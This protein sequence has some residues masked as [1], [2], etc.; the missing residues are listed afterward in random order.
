MRFGTGKRSI[1]K[2]GKATVNPA[3]IIFSHI[4]SG[5]MGVPLLVIHTLK[6]RLHNL[7]I[8]L[9]V[10]IRSEP[11]FVSNQDLVSGS[12]NEHPQAVHVSKFGKQI[13]GRWNVG[14]IE[15]G[16][17]IVSSSKQLLHFVAH[18]LGETIRNMNILA[19]LIYYCGVCGRNVRSLEH[20]LTH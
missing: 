16:Q 7:D 18:K 19:I 15:G 11:S 1:C 13:V 17:V 3:A 2:E 12:M 14:G 8:R 20:S 4:G 9:N 10:R 6:D 5:D